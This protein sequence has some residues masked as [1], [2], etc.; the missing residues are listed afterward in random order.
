MKTPLFNWILLIVFGIISIAVFTFSLIFPAFRVQAYAPLREL[1][2]PEPAPI[3]ITIYYGTEKH[4]WLIQMRDDFLTSNPRVDGHPIKITLE[5]LGSREMILA[6]LDGSIQP[7]V[8]SPA[9]SLQISLFQDLSE[10][11]FGA[12]MVNLANTELCQSLVETPLVLVAWQERADALWGTNPGDELWN[13]LFDAATNPQGWGA[14]GHPDWGFFKFGHTNPLKSNSGFMTT[15][16]MAYEFH[17]KSSGLTTADI[18][19]PHFQAWFTELESSIT[20]FGDST[21]TYMRDIIAYGPSKY[22][23]VAVYESVAIEQA[24]NAIGR[25][26]ELYIYYPPRTLMSDHP[27]CILNAGWVSPQEREAAQLFLS[28][29]LSEPAQ[30][31]AIYDFGFRSVDPSIA[32]DLQDSPFL[33]LA[34]NGIRITN[35]PEEVEVPQGQ[36]LDALLDYW[37]R[38]ID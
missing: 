14:Y 27:Y 24:E 22:D 29:L 5:G 15:I 38:Q 36:V 6:V 20:E 13:G 21:G 19:N 33:T 4:D 26:G 32:L 1:I 34:T 11:K 17:Q 35:L 8:L 25:Y 23:M 12:S 28:Y 10:Q 3:E 2:S 30:T 9:S 7:T 31:S 16:L 18:Q 37:A